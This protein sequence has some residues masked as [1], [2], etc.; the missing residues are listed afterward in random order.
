[1]MCWFLFFV[2]VV[3]F[4]SFVCVFISLSVA[5]AKDTSGGYW[6]STL[7]FDNAKL[8]IAWFLVRSPELRHRIHYLLAC[9]S[10][11]NTNYSTDEMGISLLM[12]ALHFLCI[13]III[14]HFFRSLFSSNQRFTV[15]WSDEE[16]R[17]RTALERAISKN[18]TSEN[19]WWQ[20]ESRRPHTHTSTRVRHWA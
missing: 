10:F 16:Q 8:T 3:F 4:S 1:M 11:P 19:Q 13:E 20:Q 12:N 7:L 6:A 5:C 15:D 2:V 18:S 9:F 17:R 14:F